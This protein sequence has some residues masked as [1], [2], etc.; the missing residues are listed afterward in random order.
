MK[1]TTINY[2]EIEKN[3]VEAELYLVDDAEI[4]IASYGTSAR[5]VKNAINDLRKKGIKAGMIRPITLWPFPYNAFKNIP[6]CCKAVMSV[7]LSMGQM[8]QDVKLGVNG[9]Y[10][11]GFYGRCGGNLFDSKEVITAIEKYYKEVK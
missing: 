3:E 4:I 2:A 5:I 6:E 1:I 11:V 10:Q 9:K 7:E 8:I